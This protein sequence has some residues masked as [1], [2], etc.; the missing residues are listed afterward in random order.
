MDSGTSGLTLLG[1]DFFKY[2]PRLIVFGAGD[3][4]LL[5]Q[6]YHNVYNM[7]I[8]YRYFQKLRWAAISGIGWIYKEK[9]GP[10][11]NQAKYIS[12]IR[13]IL[14]VNDIDMKIVSDGVG[15]YRI[16]LPEPINNTLLVGKQNRVS[17]DDGS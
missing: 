10:G 3:V 13:K 16:L 15:S 2:G 12:K 8:L 11:D 7:S 14:K 1:I 4:N 17:V 5:H 9:L 6:L